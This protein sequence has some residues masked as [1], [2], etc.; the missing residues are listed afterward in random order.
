[1]RAR[2]RGERL[3]TDKG[4]WCC[5]PSASLVL[6]VFGSNPFASTKFSRSCATPPSG[7]RDEADPQSDETYD[8]ADAVTATD[9]DANQAPV[10]DAPPELGE[11]DDERLE[12]ALPL[13]TINP[14]RAMRIDGETGSLTPGK[15]ADII[16][17]DRDLTAIAPEEIVS[18]QVAATFFEGR[19]VYG[20]V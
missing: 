2:S 10:A 18:T 20:T 7:A 9:G 4:Q 15:S 11:Q 17:L 3:A 1:M 14:A 16:V 12:E 13:F 5:T 6:G 19:C 8:S